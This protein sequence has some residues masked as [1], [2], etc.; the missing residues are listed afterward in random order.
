MIFAFEQ[1]EEVGKGIDPMMAALEKY[2]IDTCFRNPCFSR[3]WRRRKI[4]VQ[5]G[6]QDGGSDSG[7]YG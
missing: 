1:A 4:S 6:P 2:A 3:N 7:I 5:S